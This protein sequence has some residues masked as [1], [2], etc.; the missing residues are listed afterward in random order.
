MQL[1]QLSDEPPACSTGF[2]FS[3]G[4]KVPETNSNKFYCRD[5]PCRMRAWLRYHSEK[6][7]IDD[8]HEWPPDPERK[9]P[10]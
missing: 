10:S 8:P 7:P 5:S 2:C 9:A 1:F 3:C 4:E 6:W